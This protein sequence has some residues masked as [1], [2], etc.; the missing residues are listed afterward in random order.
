M[1]PILYYKNKKNEIGVAIMT[2]LTNSSSILLWQDVVKEAED[3]CATSLATEIETYLVWLLYRYTT[4]TE[5]VRKVVAPVFLEALQSQEHERH[6][7]LQLVGDHCLLY[8][9][10]FPHAQ[11]RRLVKIT[12]FVSLGRA[13]YRGLSSRKNDLYDALSM[14]FV[15]LMDVLQS[16]RPQPD[17]LPLEAYDQWKELGSQRALKILRSY[18]KG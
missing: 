1:L 8:T 9:G 7:S 17:L 2:M 15:P 11:E 4:K 12:Y 10:L 5:M 18:T 6:A 14:Q 3:Q 13:A 16:I